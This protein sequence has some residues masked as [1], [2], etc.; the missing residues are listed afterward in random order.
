MEPEPQP[1]PQP[2]KLPAWAIKILQ[3]LVV[4]LMGAGAGGGGLYAVNRTPEPTP[5]EVSLAEEFYGE[6]GELIELTAQTTGAR[7]RWRSLD[8][9]LSL[10]D[11]LPD[12][13]AR[14]EVRAI[15]CASG[16]Y[17]V[18]CWSAIGNEPTRIYR[19]VVIVGKP[20]PG[21]NPPTPVPPDP[22]PPTPVPPTPVPPAPTSE[23][24]RKLQACWSADTTNLVVKTSQR[25]LIIGL[26]EAMA[27]HAK[28]EK[29]TTTGELLGDL[30]TQAAAMLLPSALTECRKAISAEV[31]AALGTDPATV[32]DVAFRLKAVDVFNRVAKAMQEVK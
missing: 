22:T 19:T 12:L 6:P 32:L 4:L 8:V 9:G 5:P 30:K 14:K 2:K 26:Y 17:R 11:D 16:K 24:A 20:G 25:A 1:A 29:I 10:I 13:I 21:P 18:E 23:L 7:V 3:W 31:A 27:D 15:A 28:N